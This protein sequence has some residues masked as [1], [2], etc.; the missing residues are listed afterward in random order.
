MTSTCEPKNKNG[1]NGRDRTLEPKFLPRDL[2]QVPK[3]SYQLLLRSGACLYGNEK[4]YNADRPSNCQ[5]LMM[6]FAIEKRLS[7]TNSQEFENSAK[8]MPGAR[9]VLLMTAHNLRRVRSSE[10]T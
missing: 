5:I 2:R 4:F 7:E 6:K 8:L 9:M 10:D 1:T 3:G